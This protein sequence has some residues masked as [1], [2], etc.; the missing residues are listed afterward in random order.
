[1]TP[2][3]TPAGPASHA[4]VPAGPNDASALS[5]VI[6]EAFFPLAPCQ[7]LVPD[8]VERRQILPPYFQIYVERALTDGL[9]HTT[10]ARDAAA[11]WI[12]VGP[13]GPGEPPDDYAERLAAVTGPWLDRFTVL[14][15]NFDRHHPAGAAHQHL[16]I[17]AVRPGRQ[18]EGIGT[19]LL[20]AHHATLDKLGMPAYLEASDQRTRGIYLD[21]GYSDCGSPI[22]LPEGPEMYPMWRPPQ[23]HG[24]SG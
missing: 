12:P 11:L 5:Q 3:H 19:A 20:Q 23:D 10:P 2:Q 17:L 22:E 15:E 24:R 1:M 6:A 13:D 9:V 21:H 4:I 14:D 16:A 18:G 7:W 8:G